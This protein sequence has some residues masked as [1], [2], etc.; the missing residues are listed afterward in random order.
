MVDVQKLVII[1]AHDVA[2]A[3]WQE[4]LQTW[5]TLGCL[6]LCTLVTGACPAL[7]ALCCPS[8]SFCNAVISTSPA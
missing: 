4:R 2:A 5:P 1:S 8:V 3:R 6:Q 7:K